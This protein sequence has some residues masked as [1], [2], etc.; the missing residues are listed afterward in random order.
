MAETIPMAQEEIREVLTIPGDVMTKQWEIDGAEYNVGECYSISS[1]F[2]GASVNLT[3][4]GTAEQ[5]RLIE[6]DLPTDVSP[7]DLKTAYIEYKIEA[8]NGT[9]NGGLQNRHL[10]VDGSKCFLT[11]IELYPRDYSNAKIH[12]KEDDLS[13]IYPI[14]IPYLNDRPI[15][16]E[17]NKLGQ[18]NNMHVLQPYGIPIRQTVNSDN[19]RYN[20]QQ[21]DTGTFSGG[22]YSGAAYSSGGA[23]DTKADFI[24]TNYYK[25]IGV[26]PGGAFNVNNPK[27]VFYVREYLS[28]ICSFF[29]HNGGLTYTPACPL[30]MRANLNLASTIFRKGIA[31]GDN[32]TTAYNVFAGEYSNG[33]VLPATTGTKNAAYS[34]KLNDTTGIAGSTVITDTVVLNLQR[35]RIVYRHL[36]EASKYWNLVTDGYINSGR[37]LQFDY[38]RRFPSSTFNT[39]MITHT[40]TINLS[41]YDK[42]KA[43]CI[44]F[45]KSGVPD[46]NVYTTYGGRDANT[47]VGNGNTAMDIYPTKSYSKNFPFNHSDMTQYSMRINNR[48]IFDYFNDDQIIQDDFIAENPYVYANYLKKKPDTAVATISVNNAVTVTNTFVKSGAGNGTAVNNTLT[49]STDASATVYTLT[50]TGLVGGVSTS[51]YLSD[52][53]FLNSRGN[54]IIHSWDTIMNRYGKMENGDSVV[55]EGGIAYPNFK[56]ELKTTHKNASNRSI[57]V[58]VIG[59]KKLMIKGAAVN[60]VVP[61]L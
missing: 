16:K 42:I 38:I 52:I 20:Q 6:F 25:Y 2:N 57:D 12:Q 15:W 58:V 28:E 43:I 31:A 44:L 7:M 41:D 27:M 39:N 19:K 21:A 11:D 3:G 55:Y 35:V 22:V 48:Q 26:L 29:N 54:I 30:R 50:S 34:L 47:G 51:T 17:N 14:L 5:K 59:S 4:A 8:Y 33:D 37:I 45:N 36:K 40:T 61:R 1:T 23:V 46:T 9:N 18:Y 49:L 56:I 13:D 53:E 60:I 10:F 24:D 32:L